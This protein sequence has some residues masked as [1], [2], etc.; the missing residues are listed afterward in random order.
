M[1]YDVQIEVTY[2]YIIS[3]TISAKSETDAQ[4]KVKKLI[5]NPSQRKL[6]TEWEW[7]DEADFVGD[8]EVLLIEE[9]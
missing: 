7:G 6:E 3:K 4:N 1:P 5:K 2:K 8:I 9:C